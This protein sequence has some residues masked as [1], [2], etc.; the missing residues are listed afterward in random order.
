L[1][2]PAHPQHGLALLLERLKL[3]RAAVSDW[4]P[5]RHGLAATPPSRA[6]VVAEAL[7]PAATTESWREIRGTVDPERWRLALRG[8]SRIDC[9]GPQEE[10]GVIA[11]RLRQALEVD[12]R[13]AALVTPDRDLARRVAGELRRWDIAIDDSAGRPLAGTAPGS[14][15]RLV[16]DLAATE[17]APVPLLAAL[18]HPLAAAG[19]EPA[20]FRAAVRRLELALL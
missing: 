10:A 14:F 3:D 8:V 15:L 9:A 20:A 1:A 2:D 19:E 13:R 16:A 4:L 7:R 18:K 12:G 11:L 6:R 5:A 17:A